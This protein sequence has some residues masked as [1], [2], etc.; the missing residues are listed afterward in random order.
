MDFPCFITPF[1]VTPPFPIAPF[2]AGKVKPFVGDEKPF[3][4]E[5]P[6]DDP[7]GPACA[8]KSGDTDKLESWSESVSLMV[9]RAGWEA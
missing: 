4:V 5:W 8:V 1:P 6:F 3:R 7:E 2:V 9:P